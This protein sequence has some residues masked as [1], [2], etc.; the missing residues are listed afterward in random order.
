MGRLTDT[1]NGLTWAQAV[2]VF[3]GGGL[4]ISIGD[5]AHIAFGVLTQNDTSFWGQA[6]WV[7]PMF[8][9]VSLSL[10]VSYRALRGWLDEPASARDPKSAGLSAALFLLAYCSTGPFAQLGLS[11][12]ALLVGL[13][14]L[15]V[16]LHRENRATLVLSIII[17]VFGPLGEVLVD[18]L[19]MFHYTNPDLGLVHSWLPAVYL[20]GG[21]VIPKVE[22]LF[23]SDGS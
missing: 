7:V 17:A 1:R 16:L 2:V 14:V 19:G 13:F 3:I 21:L 18:K 4:L 20:H 15:R 8:G 10:V 12:A 23:S 22:A 6:W 11:L 5:R 9:A